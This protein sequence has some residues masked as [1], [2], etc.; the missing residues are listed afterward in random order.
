MC[1]ESPILNSEI[2]ISTKKVSISRRKVPTRAQSARRKSSTT[3]GRIQDLEHQRDVNSYNP[4]CAVL[5]ELEILKRKNGIWLWRTHAAEVDD[6]AS[7]VLAELVAMFREKN[8]REPTELEVSQ[9]MEQIDELKRLWR[10]AMA[11]VDNP[12]CAV[13]TELVEMFKERNGRDPTESEV[14]IIRRS[15]TASI[16]RMQRLLRGGGVQEEAIMCIPRSQ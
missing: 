7:A 4:A 2:D 14:R 3:L 13:L 16:E 11:E 6:P 10:T 12:A 1:Y 5:A 9:W 8:G 15:M